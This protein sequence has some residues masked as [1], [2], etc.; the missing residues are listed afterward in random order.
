MVLWVVVVVVVV[1]S[2]QL[3]GRGGV[4]VGLLER[5]EDMSL[6]FVIGC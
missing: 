1:G 5:W 6:G 2:H 4:C 3:R